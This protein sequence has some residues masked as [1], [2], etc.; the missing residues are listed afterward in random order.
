VLLDCCSANGI[1]QVAIYTVD[2]IVRELNFC[3]F[4]P[5]VHLR[6]LGGVTFLYCNCTLRWQ[7]Q[8]LG[9]AVLEGPIFTLKKLY[10]QLARA[11]ALFCAGRQLDRTTFAVKLPDVPK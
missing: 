7:E 4:F 6:T 3:S 8:Q 10:Q 11:G 1:R 9:E 2:V 5:L